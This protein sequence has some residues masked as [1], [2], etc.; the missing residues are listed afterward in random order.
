[1]SFAV[2]FRAVRALLIDVRQ[3]FSFLKL[4]Q[5]SMA[6]VHNDGKSFLQNGQYCILHTGL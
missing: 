6:R 4:F 2:Y 3:M 5:R 1:M